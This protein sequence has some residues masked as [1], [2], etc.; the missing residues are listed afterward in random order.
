MSEMKKI[1]AAI[2]RGTQEIL[3]EE[4]LIKLLESGRKLRVKCGFDPTAPDIHVGHTVLINKLKQFQDMGHEVLLLIGDFTARIGDP[5]GKNIAR[6]PLNETQVRENAKTYADQVF[7]ILDRNKTTVVYNSEWLD[8]LSAKDMVN[9]AAK[10]TVA[11]ML[12]RED[13]SKRYREGVSISI[14]EFLY[15]LLQGYDSVHLKSDIELGGTDQRFNLLMGRELQKGAGQ[16]PQVVI[17]MP[18]LEGLDGVKKMSKS[19]DNYI[20]ITDDPNNM[21]GKVMSISDELMWRYFDLISFKSSSEISALKTQ[22]RDGLNPRDVKVM[23]AKEIIAR[24]HNTVQADEAEAQFIQQFRQGVL[25]DDLP[26]I[27]LI[28]AQET[29]PLANLLK[30]AGLTKSTSEAIRMIDQGAVK[31]D[32]EKVVGADHPIRRGQTTVAQVG[33]RRFAKI[34]V[35]D[36]LPK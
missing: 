10:Q 18:L 8:N 21:F 14:H 25:P 2:A 9:L 1:V 16:T 27:E 19:L 28:I 33:K 12:E 20:G 29:I 11:R 30:E 17:T 36:T 34:K 26:E 7:K 31:L 4:E 3:L 15:P 6:Q 22:V 5:T 24:F 35:L 13:F 32:G 23:L